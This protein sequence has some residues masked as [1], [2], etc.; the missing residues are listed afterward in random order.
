MIRTLWLRLRKIK[1]WRLFKRALV[2]LGFKP[3]EAT[4]ALDRVQSRVG[5]E[6]TFEHLFREALKH[7]PNPATLRSRSEITP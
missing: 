1:L 6:T 3:H 7:C 4:G 5:P 2:S